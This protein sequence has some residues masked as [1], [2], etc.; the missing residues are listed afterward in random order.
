[1]KTNRQSLKVSPGF[2]RVGLVVGGT[3]GLALTLAIVGIT[4]FFRL[5]SETAALRDCFLD[6]MPGQWNKT[7]ALRVGGFT[8][9]L[10]RAGLRFVEMEPEA[11]QA[12]EAVRGGEVGIYNLER[13]PARIDQA[14]VIARADRAMQRRG[15][16][17]VVGVCHDR[18]LV[19]VYL[20]N[21]VS[22]RRLKCCVLVFEGKQ[23]I[24]AEAA[25]NLEPILSI[26]SKHLEQEL[27]GPLFARR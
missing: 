11:R 27:G 6:G 14:K 22:S 12:L 18:E 5:S 15:W 1:M 3:L 24:V 13:E 25:G 17:R 19:A 8:T 9:G 4:G 23:L 2:V 10:V 26:A 21:K 16:T 20:P 7:I